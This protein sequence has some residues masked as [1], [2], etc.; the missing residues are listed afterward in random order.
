[1]TGAFRRILLRREKGKHRLTLVPATL[2]AKRLQP[3]KKIEPRG[4]NRPTFSFGYCLVSG[5]VSVRALEPL[6]AGIR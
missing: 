4:N 1:M 5:I 3:G 2:Y 6:R